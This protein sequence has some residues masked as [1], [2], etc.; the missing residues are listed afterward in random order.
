[1]LPSTYSIGLDLKRQTNNSSTYHTLEGHFICQNSHFSCCHEYFPLELSCRTIGSCFCS[2][3]QFPGSAKVQEDVRNS[4][5]A[6]AKCLYVQY[7]PIR[8]VICKNDCGT[9]NTPVPF[10]KSTRSALRIELSDHYNEQQPKRSLGGSNLL[11][12]ESNNIF[13]QIL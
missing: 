3:A 13:S 12:H 1:M 6:K 8:W 7:L 11:K 5:H 4:S 10:K 9:S 2:S